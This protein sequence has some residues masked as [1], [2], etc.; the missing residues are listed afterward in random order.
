MRLSMEAERPEDRKGPYHKR[1]EAVEAIPGTRAGSVCALECGH[2]ILVFGPLER[3][4]G[5]ALCQ[6]CRSRNLRG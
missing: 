2:R 1:I 4:D 3:L 6:E 5:V